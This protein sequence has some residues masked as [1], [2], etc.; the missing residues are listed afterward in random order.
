MASI[1]FTIYALFVGM[2]GAE[3]PQGC[4]R[5]EP[6]AGA[7]DPESAEDDGCATDPED[8]GG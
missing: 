6:C 7:P 4:G 5:A 8:V 3:G 2:C 1:L